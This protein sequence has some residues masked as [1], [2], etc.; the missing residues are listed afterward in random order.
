MPVNSLADFLIYIAP[1][2]V[3]YET[4]RTRFPARERNTF[5]HV[6]IS[7]ILALLIVIALRY[8]D[9]MIL[10]GALISGTAS[11]VA[12]SALSLALLG[13]GLV[14]GLLAILQAELRIFLSL[15]VHWLGWLS[16]RPESVWK[17]I[18]APDNKG[19]ALVLLPDGSHYLGWIS[20]WA[21]DPNQGGQEFLLKYAKRVKEDL[22]EIHLVDGI[23]VYLNKWI[24]L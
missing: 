6:S 2:F 13:S 17:Q 16:G 12:D 4:Y 8:L 11:P 15:R 19:W 14:A 23:G 7:V 20:E 10:K 18:N 24:Q 21:Y 5:A 9:S 22:S 3:A 1:G